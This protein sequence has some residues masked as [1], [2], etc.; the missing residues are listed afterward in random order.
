MREFLG[1][2]RW[3]MESSFFLRW[4]YQKKR[5]KSF[6]KGKKFILPKKKNTKKFEEKHW[7]F[8]LVNY[9]LPR[10]KEEYIQRIGRVN[11]FSK[12]RSVINFA[13]TKETQELND[14]EKYYCT[15]FKLLS[16]LSD[17][18]WGFLLHI[19]FKLCMMKKWKKE[20]KELSFVEKFW[21][22]R[23]ADKKL[24]SQVIY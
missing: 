15:E 2:E 24:K 17:F 8:S 1:F 11:R 20:E 14:L 19:C 10:A 9:E 18:Y 21:N 4:M 22:L 7:F 12:K 23:E 3:D 16:D 5:R 6:W 13:T